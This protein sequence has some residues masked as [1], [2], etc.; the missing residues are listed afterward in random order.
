[1]SASP[2]ICANAYG[3]TSKIW[4]QASPKSTACTCCV[5][6]TARR[7]ACGDHPRKADQEVEPGMEN[8]VNRT[9]EPRLARPL[10]R[11]SVGLDSRLRGN[12][13]GQTRRERRAPAWRLDAANLRELG[14]G[15]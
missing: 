7:H 2:A 11:H 3:N 8:P 15:G 12:D 4:L 13:A 14:Y 9:H 6:R 5:L 10:A 1:M